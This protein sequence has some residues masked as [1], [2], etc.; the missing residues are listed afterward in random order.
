MCGEKRDERVGFLGKDA[1]PQLGR[2]ESLPQLGEQ[3]VGD[4]D[5]E[6]PG[7]PARDDF[8]RRSRR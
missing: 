6:A 3:M 7:E 4:D 5:L 1:P 8:R 2:C